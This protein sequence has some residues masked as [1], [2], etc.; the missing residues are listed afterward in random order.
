MDPF[1]LSS[2]S[3]KRVEIERSLER[4]SELTWMKIVR[5]AIKILPF[6]DESVRADLS[7]AL[8]E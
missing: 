2:E 1:S 4:W 7:G 6:Q 5:A 8:F 3:V